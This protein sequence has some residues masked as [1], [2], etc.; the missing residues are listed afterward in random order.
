MRTTAAT[1]RCAQDELPGDG[2][3]DFAGI[4]PDRDFGPAAHI[5]GSG[6]IS[7][8]PARRGYALG[9]AAALSVHGAGFAAHVAGGLPKA[10][11]TQAPGD[12]LILHAGLRDG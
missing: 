8:Q 3:N 10:R 5:K 11:G 4:T 1:E 2:T 6:R 12:V 9:P 7:E